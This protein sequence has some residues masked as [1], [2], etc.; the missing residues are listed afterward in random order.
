M[1]KLAWFAG[2]FSGGV[3]L[4]VYL[5]PAGKL[6]PVGLCCTAGGFAGRRLRGSLGL[7]LLLLGLGLGLSLM[8]TWV[9]PTLF[10]ASAAHLAGT[11]QEIEAQV[12]AWPEREEGWVEVQ[13]RQEDEWCKALLWLENVPEGIR[14]GDWVYTTAS[15]QEGELDDYA[16]GVTLLAFG[17]GE[18]SVTR[19]DRVPVRFWP[20]YVAHAIQQSALTCFP[21]E[22]G[23]LTAALITGNTSWLS[24]RFYSALRRTGAA[25]VVA[26]S[27]LHVSFFAGF[28]S[29]LLGRY[30]KRSAAVA[31]ALIFFFAAAAGNTPSVLRA[32]FTHAMLLAAPL[33]NRQSDGRTSL[34][35]ILMLLLIQNPYAAASLSLQLSFGA[36]AGILIFTARLSRRWQRK[37]ALCLHGPAQ[38][39]RCMWVRLLSASVA[40]TL[41]A[42]IFTVPLSAIYFRSVTIIAPLANLLV[43]W[44]VSCLFLGGLIVSVL[45]IFLP[46]VA[47]ILAIPVSLVGRYLLWVVPSLAAFPF[48]SVSAGSV[49][50]QAWLGLVYALIL[51]RKLL[52]ERGS[53]IL[54]MALSAAALCWAVVLHGASYT[55]GELTVSVL[56]VGQ[57]LSVALYS[58]G[59]AALVDCGGNGVDQAGDKAADYFQGLGLTRVDV[60]ILTHYHDDHANGV[61]RLMERME[62]DLLVLPD[63]EPENPLRQTIQAL[64]EAE[65]VET[66]FLEE[67]AVLTLGGTELTVYPPM[68]L[69]GSNEE[70]LSVW[71]AAGEFDGL[72]TGDMNQSSEARLL[73]EESLP[74]MDLLVVGH[75]GSKYAASEELLLATQPETAVISVGN[76]AYGHPADETMERLASVGCQIYRTDWSGTVTIIAKQEEEY[77]A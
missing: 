64:A 40:T 77:A 28:V 52:R 35:T 13:I 50:I 36:T 47:A 62:V 68:G 22:T 61:E 27:G 72:I 24:G 7:R 44:A 42:L 70:G 55:S 71:V 39:L 11:R 2:A 14:P 43:L 30:S 49:Y 57:G 45:G 20:T 9:Y 3:F 33:F 56:D 41:G 26:V 54:P 76:N 5:L 32:A 69:G 75:H 23:G 25:H 8:W 17:T 65:Q 29:A 66:I 53:F 12:T 58:Q 18:I 73:R 31:I 46:S 63:V 1:R 21:G 6:L 10:H 74:Q 15:I 34:C 37:F 51:A 38:R 60:V 48:A 59:R 19:S 16:K 4:A 67:K